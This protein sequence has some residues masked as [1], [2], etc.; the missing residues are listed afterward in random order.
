MT[1]YVF[2]AESLGPA[3]FFVAMMV[4]VTLCTWWC[5]RRDI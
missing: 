4:W 1:V 2:D 3:A 5:A